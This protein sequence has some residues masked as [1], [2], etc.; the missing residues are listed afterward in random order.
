MRLSKSFRY[1]N[2]RAVQ[3]SS[4]S[5]YYEYT[6]AGSGEGSEFRNSKDDAHCA[7]AL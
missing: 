1:K 4:S 7:A 5:V 6:A 2:E 3:K